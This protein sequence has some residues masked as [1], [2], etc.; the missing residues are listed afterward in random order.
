MI[1]GVICFGLLS[2]SLENLPDK[3]RKGVG[4]NIGKKC[5]ETHLQWALCTQTLHFRPGSPKVFPLQN[6]HV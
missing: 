4:V 2:V 1:T 5:N 3:I 6:G